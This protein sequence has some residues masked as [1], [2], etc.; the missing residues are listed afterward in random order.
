MTQTQIP[1][2]GGVNPPTDNLVSRSRGI[3]NASVPSLAVIPLRQHVGAPA[4]CVVKP[5]DLVE[6]G[7]LIGSAEGDDSANVHAS[8]P[9]RVV[10]IRRV[11][12]PGAAPCDAVVVELGG[13]FGRSGQ[14]RRKRGWDGVS[15]TELLARIR[16][17]GVVG[18]SGSVSPTHRKLALPTGRSTSVLVA[19]GLGGEPALTADFAL[20]RERAREIAEAMRICRALLDPG[21]A[22][23]ALPDD[24]GELVPAFEEAFHELH[25][26]AEAVLVSSRYPQGHADL[27]VDAIA[28]QGAVAEAVV[29]NVGTL[30]AIYDAVVGD[31]PLIERVLTVAGTPVSEPRNLKVR[32]GTRI[33]DLFE[34]CGGLTEPV[35]KVVVGGPM[36]GVAVASLDVPV[37]KGTTGVI[38]FTER[39]A[40]A[41]TE[42]PCVRCGNCVEVCPWGL[43]PTR[44]FKLIE[45]GDFAGAGDEGLSRCTECGCCAYSCPS[46][47]P[48]V[49]VIRM[50]KQGRNRGFND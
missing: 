27:L 30:N 29:L 49:D 8:I 34:E 21:R 12:L 44:L 3:T 17:A 33:G 18:L 32:I 47:I 19:N 36:R 43:I 20:M 23:I 40:H 5:G 28:G 22:V 11:S 38:A 9:G 39:E 24:A 2:S 35:G 4:R 1:L 16:A 45:K 37:T 15:R 10:E 25:V 13:R 50:G 48:L 7:M 26:Q 41:P 31:Q 6:E 46:H 42:W 14:P